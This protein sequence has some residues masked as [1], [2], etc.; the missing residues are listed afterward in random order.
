MMPD[1]CDVCGEAPDDGLYR[2]PPDATE[3]PL[4]AVY[5]LECAITATGNPPDVTYRIV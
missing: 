3:L 5:C 1:R 2:L 4:V